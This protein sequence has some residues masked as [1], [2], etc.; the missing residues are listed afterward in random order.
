MPNLPNWKTWESQ[1]TKTIR[2]YKFGFVFGVM[3]CITGCMLISYAVWKGWSEISNSTNPLSAFWDFL[4]IENIDLIPIVEFRLVYLVVL[5]GA[6]LCLGVGVI[7]FSRQ[8]F[9]LPGK[10]MKLQCSFCKKFFKAGY[11]TGQV[12]CP[13]CRHLVHPRIVEK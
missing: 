2:R 6:I 3:L 12:L 8:W 13:H 9:F 7:A 11:N 10:T 1:L 4:W 5:A